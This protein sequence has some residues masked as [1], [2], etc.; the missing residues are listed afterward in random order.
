MDFDEDIDE[1]SRSIDGGSEN[2]YGLFDD[3]VSSEDDRPELDQ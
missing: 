3:E 1:R 2:G